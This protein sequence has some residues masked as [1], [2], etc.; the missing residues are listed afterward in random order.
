[1][2]VDFIMVGYVRKSDYE[3][4]EFDGEWVILNTDLYT[5]TKLNNIGGHCWSLLGEEQTVESLRMAIEQRFGP[6]D[7]EVGRHIESF[8]AELMDYGLIQYAT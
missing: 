7:V 8:L 4:A 6:V 2:G 5:V 1:L 3:T